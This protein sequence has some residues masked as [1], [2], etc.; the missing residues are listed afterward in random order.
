[1]LASERVA[2]CSSLQAR[3]V[4]QQMIRHELVVGF[5]S[6]DR[7]NLPLIAFTRVQVAGHFQV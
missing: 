6:C 2:V 7:C 1:M 4:E 5:E 3:R